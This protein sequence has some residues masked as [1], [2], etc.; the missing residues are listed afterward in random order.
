MHT[1][2]FLYNEECFQPEKVEGKKQSVRQVHYNYIINWPNTENKIW[3]SDSGE[4]TL[5]QT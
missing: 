5:R 2:Y 4:N 3:C 1:E